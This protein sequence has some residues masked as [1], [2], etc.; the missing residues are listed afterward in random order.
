MTLV[1]RDLTTKVV[2]K[3]DLGNPLDAANVPDQ[4]DVSLGQLWD[5]LGTQKNRI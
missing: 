2:P 4:P 1:R 3:V 5:F